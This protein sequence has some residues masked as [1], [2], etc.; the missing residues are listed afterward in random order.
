[1]IESFKCDSFR[2]GARSVFVSTSKRGLD[3]NSNKGTNTKNNNSNNNNNNRSNSSSLTSKQM[4]PG[5]AFYMPK[6][7]GRKSFHINHL[8]NWTT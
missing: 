3:N 6:Q 8:N 1:M 2:T 4:H 7:I 5:P